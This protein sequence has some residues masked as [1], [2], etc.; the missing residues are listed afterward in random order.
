MLF[1][2]MWNNQAID[3]RV[4]FSKKVNH[5]RKL[6]DETTFYVLKPLQPLQLDLPEAK[7]DF[8]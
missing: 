3:I 5:I 8:K 7:R 4:G 1:W 2:I 6:V